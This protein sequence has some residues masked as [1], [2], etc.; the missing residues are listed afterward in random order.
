MISA[1]IFD[2]DDTLY[3]ERDFVM[4]GLSAVCKYLSTKYW[5]DYNKLFSETEN[6]LLE[7]GRGAIF[8]ILCER[9]KYNED[10]HE[11][12][13]IYRNAA[14]SLKLYDDSVYILEELSGKYKLGLITDGMAAV[15]W[16]KIKLL[17]IEAYFDRIIVTD[18]FGKD[19]WKPNEFAYTEILK[20][21][22]VSAA[23]AIYVGDNPN[24]DFI[25]ARKV[26]MN[27]VRIIREQ[28]DHKAVRLD[29]NHEADLEIMDLGQLL[30]I[31]RM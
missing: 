27:T 24:K 29:E 7:K 12:V 6:I 13:D 14:P 9:H 15:Q 30:D 23:E 1:V 28:G 16:N 25:G 4:G 20:E 17:N 3:N 21:F 22:N 18:D 26:G 8:N 5:A 19:Y 31:I 2:L 10:I 11:L